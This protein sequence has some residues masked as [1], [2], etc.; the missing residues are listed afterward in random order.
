MN[1]IDC[2]APFKLVQG[3][4]GWFLASFEDI[5]IGRSLLTY[6]EY[7]EIEWQAIA[8]LVSLA[9]DV[10][11]VGANIGALSV[12]M[13]R[14]LAKR[15]RRLLAVEAQP[16]IHRQLCANL[17]LNALLNVHAENAACSDAP[18]WL[19]FDAPDYHREFNFGAVAMREDG[20]GRQRVRAVTVDELVPPDFDVGLL[21]IDVEGFEQRVLEGARATLTRCR[22]FVYLENDRVEQSRALIEWLFAASYQLYWHVPLMFNAG[23]FAGES[24]DIYPQVGSF[25]MLAVPN[26]RPINLGGQQ[27]ISDPGEHPL[28]RPRG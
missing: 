1:V 15:G 17:A 25:N 5:Y 3:R 12:P 4:H 11:E 27:P 14:T 24:M 7:G 16:M 9:R 2:T 19:S 28:L 26:E 22:P 23:N 6:G 20:A 10:V 21:K 13:A 18:G 8:P